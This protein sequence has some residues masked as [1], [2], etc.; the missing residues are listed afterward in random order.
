MN[1]AI[2]QFL[3][4]NCDFDTKYAFDKLG[5]STTFC[6]HGE[7]SLPKGTDLVVLPGGFSYGDY[8]RTGAIAATSKI[9]EAVRNYA[10]NGGF[11]LGICNG[12]QI[13]LEAKL[14]PGAMLRNR[15]L[16]FI[17]RF[18]YLKIENTDN[19]FLS[20]FKKGEIINLPIA[21]ADGNYYVDEKTYENLKKNGQILLTYV[22]ENGSSLSP[23]GSL[24]NIA[25]ICNKTKNVF[26]LMPHPE[27]AI[28]LALGSVD[29]EKMLKSFL[30]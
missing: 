24:G 4:S 25:G 29:G 19:K 22:D 7:G 6:P 8:L 10:K 11:V 2:V 17:S 14:L 5:F 23:N 26:A 30:S 15:D 21:H 18:H 3:G 12:F 16:N 13:L 9:M 28:E 27:R 20:Q 1:V